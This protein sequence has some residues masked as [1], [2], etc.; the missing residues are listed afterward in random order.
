MLT[1]KSI[2]DV[3]R[4]TV[5]KVQTETADEPRR[6]I[7]L[8]GPVSPLLLKTGSE[9]MQW[10]SLQ[11]KISVHSPTPVLPLNLYFGGQLSSQLILDMSMLVRSNSDEWC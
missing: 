1:V 11:R 6:V 3:H 9:G 7:S 5:E 2:I 10:F 4:S 8:S